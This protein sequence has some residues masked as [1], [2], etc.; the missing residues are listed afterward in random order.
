MPKRLAL[1]VLACVLTACAGPSALH[2][3]A[4]TVEAPVAPAPA[5]GP[6]AEALTAGVLQASVEVALRVLESP[7]SASAARIVEQ[8]VQLVG[9]QNLRRWDARVPNDCSGFVRVAYASAGIDLVRGGFLDGENAVSAIHR[10]A[11]RQGALHQERPRPGDLDFFRETYDR[12]RDGRRNDGMTH[13]GVVERVEE[14]GTVTFIH[15]GGKGVARSRMNL[16]RPTTFREGH[17]GP[18]LNDFL[19]PRSKRERAWLSGELFVG[20]A[21]ADGM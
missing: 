12:N 9:E 10:L 15:R 21:S 17:A 4:R 5:V 6:D 13:I 1:L 14:D 2:R 8:A 16:E 3:P 11:T 20:F 7:H 19:R 18:V